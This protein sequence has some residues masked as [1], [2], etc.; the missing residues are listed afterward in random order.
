M[1]FGDERVYKGK[2]FNSHRI[3]LVHQHVLRFIASEVKMPCSCY[4]KAK[5][6]QSRVRK[7]DNCPTFG[8]K[9]TAA[10]LSRTPKEQA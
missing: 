8:N 2:E 4:P 7:Q 9:S 3:V 10:A 5:A 1:H 6:I